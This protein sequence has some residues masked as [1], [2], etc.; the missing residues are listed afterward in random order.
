M[1]IK[2]SLEVF[3]GIRQWINNSSITPEKAGTFRIW[4]DENR[5]SIINGE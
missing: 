4:Y 2:L 5:V 1:K 3:I